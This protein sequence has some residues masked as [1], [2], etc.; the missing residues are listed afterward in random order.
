M[1]HT[2]DLDILQCNIKRAYPNT[3]TPV[4]N[5]FLYIYFYVDV[6]LVFDAS[7]RK[8]KLISPT[9]IIL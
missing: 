4:K 3:Y 8:A 1:L 7:Y 5:L 9:T 2:L 6:L